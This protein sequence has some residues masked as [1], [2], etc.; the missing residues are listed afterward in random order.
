MDNLSEKLIPLIATGEVKQYNPI[1]VYGKQYQVDR[2]SETV[3]SASLKEDPSLRICVLSGELFT[4]Q[5]MLSLRG[6]YTETFRNRIRMADM[7]IFT[8][9]D[10]IQGKTSTM[11]EFFSLFDYYYEQGKRIIVGSS[12]PYS[13]LFAMEDRVMAQLQGGLI[14]ELKDE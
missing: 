14:V 8:D 10:L 11:W 7:L 9:V 6:D 12:V 3:Q 1:C 5:L 13:D 4:K 2:F